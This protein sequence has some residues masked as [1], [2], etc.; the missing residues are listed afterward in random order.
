[1]RNVSNILNNNLVTYSQNVT[2]D[3]NR[4][5]FQSDNLFILEYQKLNFRP[6]NLGSNLRETPRLAN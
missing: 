4:K 2:G 5:F 1:M 3:T 6:N